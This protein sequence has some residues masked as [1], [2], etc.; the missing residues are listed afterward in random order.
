MYSKEIVNDNKSHSVSISR[1]SRSHG[2]GAGG[3]FALLNGGGTASTVEGTNIGITATTG[4]AA[5]GITINTSVPRNQFYHK[6]LKIRKFTFR[7]RI[8]GAQISDSK[9]RIYFSA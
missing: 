2:T 3:S 7:P 5:T 9:K 4:T 8:S 6:N 1:H